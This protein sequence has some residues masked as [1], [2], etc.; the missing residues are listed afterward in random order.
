MSSSERAIDQLFSGAETGAFPPSAARYSGG[1]RWWWTSIRRA[2]AVSAARAQRRE[3][4]QERPPRRRAGTETAVV[5][6]TGHGVSSSSYRQP[7]LSRDSRAARR[8]LSS[9]PVPTGPVVYDRAEP[10]P[11]ESGEP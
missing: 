2:A 10:C 6:R 8:L 1:A 4:L 9:A 5:I 11:A 7:L 3:A